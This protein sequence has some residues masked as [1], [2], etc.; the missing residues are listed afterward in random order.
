MIRFP[1]GPLKTYIFYD[2]R[3]LYVLLKKSRNKP[4]AFLAMLH[5]FCLECFPLRRIIK[6]IFKNRAIQCLLFFYSWKTPPGG[7]KSFAECQKPGCSDEHPVVVDL[8]VGCVLLKFGFVS[9]SSYWGGWWSGLWVGREGRYA[10]GPFWWKALQGSSRSAIHLPSVSQSQYLCLQVTGGEAAPASWIS[11]PM[12]ALT[13][14]ECFLFFWRRQ[15]WFWPLVLLCYFGGSFVCVAFLF[16]GEWLMS[17]QFQRVHLPPQHPI[18]DQFP[19][20]PHC[21]RFLNVW[22][23]FVF[24]V[25]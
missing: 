5:I 25:L 14:W 22:C 4:Y 19:K 24:G 1:N 18:I 16:A 17:P 8:E 15:L 3:F 21:Q 7:K 12:V 11:I 9:S 10:V 20:H 23:R 13:H 2:N 6:I